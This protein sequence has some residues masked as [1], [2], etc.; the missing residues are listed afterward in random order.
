LVFLAA[1]TFV[2]VVPEL[3]EATLLKAFVRFVG[4]LRFSVTHLVLKDAFTV[5]TRQLSVW[6][7]STDLAVIEWE[8]LEAALRLVLITTVWAI[9]VAVT[10]GTLHDAVT[11]D[12]FEHIWWAQSD[13]M[14]SLSIDGGLVPVEVSTSQW[15]SLGH[16]TDGESPSGGS[17]TTFLA[18]VVLENVVTGGE[19]EHK[20]EL[21]VL[22]LLPLGSSDL[23]DL[24]S[25]NEDVSSSSEVGRGVEL[26]GGLIVGNWE[27]DSVVVTEVRLEFRLANLLVADLGHAWESSG[28]H[29]KLAWLV[30]VSLELFEDDVLFEVM[31]GLGVDRA[32][33]KRELGDLDAVM[34]MLLWIHGGFWWSDWTVLPNIVHVGLGEVHPFAIVDLERPFG[35][36]IAAF[37]SSFDLDDVHSTVEGDAE[38]ELGRL[39]G[40]PNIALVLFDNFAV[41]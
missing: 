25:V 27:H 1:A 38:V 24:F 30:Q 16:A 23:F 2:V 12:T 18:T 8:L 26:E 20:I 19:L 37:L 35:G 11:G 3:L 31:G 21:G 29:T 14:A 9:S 39:T 10:V 32:V 13:I 22:T 34:A 41:N 7:T 28:T 17:V 36:S 6:V 4:A 33:L 40:S 5:G 15:H